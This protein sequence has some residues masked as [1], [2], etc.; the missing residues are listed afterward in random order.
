MRI[1]LLKCTKINFDFIN[2]KKV[3]NFHIIYKVTWKFITKFNCS[4]LIK[5]K[6][7]LSTFIKVDKCFLL[8]AK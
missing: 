1:R 2:K 7:H 8:N 4:N 6:I 5:Y 3:V